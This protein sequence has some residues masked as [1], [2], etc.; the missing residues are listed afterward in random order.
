VIVWTLIVLA[1][2]ILVVGT[3]TVWVKR[4]ALDTNNW[5]NSSSELLQD[6][7]IRQALS[8]YIVD[9]LYQNVDVSNRL[10]QRLP[11]NLQ[12]LAGPISAALREPAQRAVDQLLQRPRVQQAWEDANRIAHEQLMAIL[13]GQPRPNV[14]TVNGEVVLDLRSFVVDIGNQLGIGGKLDQTLPADAGQIV[15]MKSDQLDVAQKSVKAI[16]ALTWLLVIVT[17]VL[18]AVALWLARGWRREALRGIAA[19]VLIGGLLLLVVRQAAGNYVVD[20]LT[21]GGNVR[22]AAHHA[23][24]L[25]TSLLGEAAWAGVIYGVVGLIGIWLAGPSRFAREGRARVAP[26]LHEHVGL[27]WAGLAVAYLLVVWWGPTPALHTV[28]GVLVL[29]IL[30]AIGFEGFR[31]I[32]VAEHPAPVGS[33]E[34]PAP[35]PPAPEPP[36]P[37]VSA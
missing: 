32:V 1:F 31:R 34:P 3:M 26:F 37:A 19:S 27:A 33:P 5:T 7:K 28:A 24:L 10:Q 6:D 30:V 4:Q 16:K 15:V 2:V 8:V 13:N 36:A 22:D 23:W 21:N 25:S 9:Q 35:E 17:F 12:G 18:W 29:G 14:S 11:S 20:A